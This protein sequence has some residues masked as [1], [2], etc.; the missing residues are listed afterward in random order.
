MEEIGQN[1]NI[2]F[3]LCE[4]IRDIILK[5]NAFFWILTKNAPLENVPKNLSRALPP[6]LKFVT[7]VATGG[8]VKFLPA[9][10]KFPE[11]NAFSYTIFVEVQDLDM[12]SLTLH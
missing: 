1:I 10:K 7:T 6:E 5:R 3:W 12:P 2:V 4:T 9:V 8:R 11:N